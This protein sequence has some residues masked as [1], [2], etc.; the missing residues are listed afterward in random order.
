MEVPGPLL[1]RMNP[2]CVHA[3]LN[4]HIG[5]ATD[6]LLQARHLSVSYGDR[7]ALRGV[8]LTLS[9]GKVV[10]LLG[11]NGSGKSTLIQSLFGHLQATGEIDWFGKPLKKWSARDLARRVAYLPQTPQFQPGQPVLEVLQLGRSPYWAG[12]GL[13]SPRDAEVVRRI[14]DQLALND[15]LHRPMDELS[16]GQRQRVFVG[17]C[18]VQEP[19]V[20]L[21]DEPNTYLDLK[22]QVELCQ[23][24]RQLSKT[25]SI[26]VL[27]A[28]HD[29]N[30]ASAFADQVVVMSEGKVIASGGVEVLDPVMLSEVYGVKLMKVDRAIGAAVLIPDVQ[31]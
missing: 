29:L 30:L 6:A 22:H 21:L 27:M 10:A 16:G 12:F 13:E 25:Q 9:P 8:D 20:L 1:S 5:M 14:A 31:P 17:R 26:G 23:L 11:P 4:G 18:L 7:P 19:A 2:A 3:G 24:L 28:S 15:I